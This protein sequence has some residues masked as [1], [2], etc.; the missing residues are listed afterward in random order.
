VTLKPLDKLLSDAGID[1]KHHD[2]IE[3]YLEVLKFRH[4]PTFHH[5]LR[6]GW[7]ASRMAQ[8]ADLPGVTPKMMMW[9][10]LLHDIGKAEVPV[11]LLDKTAKFD[12]ADYAVMEPHVMAGFLLLTKVHQ[13]TAHVIVRHHRFGKRPYPEVLPPLPDHLESQQDTVEAAAR[14]LALADFYDALTTRH[15]ERS[16]GFT[17][18]E[19]RELYYREH[20]GF[21]AL[22]ERLEHA[23]VLTF[24]ST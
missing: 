15:N 10:G 13:Y 23:G 9:A 14:L 12:E 16:R 7:L 18:A 8:Y 1:E 6:V 5:V 19:Q 4:E 24:E 11:E 22:I 20:P 21:E 3:K 2:A 17:R